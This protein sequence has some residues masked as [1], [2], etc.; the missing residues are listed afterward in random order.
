MNT[1]L[2]LDEEVLAQFAKYLEKMRRIRNP[3]LPLPFHIT[4]TY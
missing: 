2:N 4:P 3:L 1:T